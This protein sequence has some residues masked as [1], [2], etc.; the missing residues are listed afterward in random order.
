MDNR[1]VLIVLQENIKRLQ[2]KRVVRTVVLVK[3][4][5]PNNKLVAPLVMLAML[6]KLKALRV[7]LNVQLGNT[8][9]TGIY[10][11]LNVLKVLIAQ[12]LA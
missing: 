9:N 5:L 7:V 1:L 6:Q 2:V 4:L 12:P 11:V 10:L 8:Q 3:P